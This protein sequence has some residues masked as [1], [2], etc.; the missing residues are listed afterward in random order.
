MQVAL[1][2]LFFNITGIIIWYPLPFMR[3]VPLHAA[4]QLGRGT[5]LWSGFPLLY[6]GVMFVAVP[7]L[8]MGLSALFT[9]DSKGLT[10]LGSFL[11]VILA[12]L[13]FWLTYYCQFQ[14]GKENCVEWMTT[15]QTRLDAVNALPDDMVFLKNKI[16][17]L[18]E[19][20]GLPE[21]EEAPA[22]VEEEPKAEEA[23]EEETA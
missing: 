22:K 14:G 21:D 20:T 8:F 12:L 19:H 11:T 17:E 23:V 2:H 1:A 4:R 13:V 10:V 7:A 6:I 5:R 9:Q 18:A 16:K 15:R 3:A